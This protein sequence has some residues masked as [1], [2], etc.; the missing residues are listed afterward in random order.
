MSGASANCA[1][2]TAHCIDGML[3]KVGVRTFTRCGI[4][5]PFDVTE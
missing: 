2:T 4:S 3:A 5:V 1:P